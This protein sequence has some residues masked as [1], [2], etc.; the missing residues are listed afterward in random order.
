MR[1]ILI[2]VLV[3]VV[4]GG[5]LFAALNSASIPVDF[6]LMQVRMPAGIALLGS[7]LTGWLLGGLVAWLGHGRLRRNLRA[8]RRVHAQTQADVARRDGA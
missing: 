1:L 2:L 3:I 7:L 4:V 6:Y 5:A 8:M